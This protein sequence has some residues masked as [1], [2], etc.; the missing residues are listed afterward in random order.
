MNKLFFSFLLLVALHSSDASCQTIDTISQ[1]L[2]RYEGELDFSGVVLVSGGDSIVLH[3]GYGSDAKKGKTDKNTVFNIAS[4]S[5]AFTAL[6]IIKLAEEHKLGLQDSI[7][8][9]FSGVP[10]DKA[11]VTIHQLL[12]HHSGIPQTYAA[13]GETD[14]NKA[15]GKIW[16]IK[17]EL[18]PGKF[19]YS[20][21]NY[22]LL[23]IIIEKVTG[24]K[25]EDYIKEAILAPLDMKN[26]Y[27][28]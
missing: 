10:V 18:Q 24:K 28:W 22:T 23:A 14:P 25:W 9:Y 15:A 13:E 4:V 5:K 19:V 12:I 27:F 2:D 26:T 8:K 6:A 20:N 7:K 11:G 17:S 16:N 21:G 1:L 3:K